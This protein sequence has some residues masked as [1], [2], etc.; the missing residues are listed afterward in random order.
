MYYSELQT[1]KATANGT[2]SGL[3][4][5]VYLMHSHITK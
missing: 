2:M 3:R 4:E 5:Q 1:F